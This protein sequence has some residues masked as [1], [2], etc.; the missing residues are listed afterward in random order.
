M[1]VVARFTAGVPVAEQGVIMAA[2][3]FE[4]EAEL[5]E[6]IGDPDEFGRRLDEFSRSARRFGANHERF[7]AEYPDQWVAVHGDDEVGADTL[8]DL[9]A[10]MEE[11]GMPRRETCIRFVTSQKRILFL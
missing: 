8:E 3:T 7:V 9:Y 4:Q 1:P 2:Y 5:L 11:R 10:K 6:L